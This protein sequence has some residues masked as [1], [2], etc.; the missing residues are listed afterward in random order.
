MK[1]YNRPDLELLDSMEGVYAASGS[2]VT[3]TPVPTQSLVPTPKFDFMLTGVDHGSYSVFKLRAY[4]CMNNKVNRYIW[5]IDF[6][7]GTRNN[8]IKSVKLNSQSGACSSVNHNIYGDK[9]II[10]TWELGTHNSGENME[11]TL[12]MVFEHDRVNNGIAPGAE[13]VGGYEGF[14]TENDPRVNEEFDMIR[15]G[16]ANVSCIIE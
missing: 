9:K 7:P 13:T 11:C 14:S 12:D 16:Y 3:G 5:T 1:S 8:K 6:L 10:W 2:V 15:M 4:N